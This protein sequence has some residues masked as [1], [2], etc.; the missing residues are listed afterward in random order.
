VIVHLVRHGEVRNPDGVV[1]AALP[2]FPLTDRGVAQ[3]REAARRLA[4]RPV[5]AV[6]SSPL[7]R[8]VQT[9]AEIAACHR[10]DVLTDHAFAE[11]MLSD[12][13]AGI[14]WVDLPLEEREAY[15][16]TPWDLPFAPESVTEMGD[17][18]K[19]GI[20][21]VSE[22]AEGDIVVVSHMDPIQA[23]RL[24]L[25]DLPPERFLVDRPSHAEIVSLARE[26]VWHERERWTPS[27]RSESFP[28]PTV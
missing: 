4:S 15:L 3:A 24:A 1:Y 26:T 27:L 10:L 17:R 5:V 11:W 7:E 21:A 8:T 18:M 28:P 22:R 20:E 25:L 14:R 9:A 13:W 12:R 6:W 23:G 16:S 19:R 2:G